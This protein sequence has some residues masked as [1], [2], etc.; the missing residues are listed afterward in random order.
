MPP[1]PRPS[2]DWSCY[3]RAR[4]LQADG[5]RGDWHG[6][7]QTEAHLLTKQ[8]K[9]F[10]FSSFPLMLPLPQTPSWSESTC[11]SCVY[12][13]TSSQPPH[14]A[15][16]SPLTH[17]HAPLLPL[18][19]VA[20]QVHLFPPHTH[21]HTSPASCNLS[22][23]SSPLPSIPP[24]PPTHIHTYL[25]PLVRVAIQGH[26]RVLHQLQANRAEQVCWGGTGGGTG[27][28]GGGVG[29]TGGVGGSLV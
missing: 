28:T 14:P 27:G 17:I 24:L 6:Q 21:P 19:C 18:I 29:G 11:P 22:H 7:Q 12:G 4:A 3:G 15:M 13:V 20:M 23:L 1:G 25:P 9:S 26:H 2:W 8:P 10:L 16:T 5:G